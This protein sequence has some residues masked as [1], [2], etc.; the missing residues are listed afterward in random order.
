[1]LKK[2]VHGE[3]NVTLGGKVEVLVKKFTK[4]S[5]VFN[6]FLS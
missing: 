6:R 2:I 3:T 5:W 1:M 4:F